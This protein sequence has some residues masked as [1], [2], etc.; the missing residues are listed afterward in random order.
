MSK[1]DIDL[2][3]TCSFGSEEGEGEIKEK[4]KLLL[5]SPLL[6]H[7]DGLPC[8]EARGVSVEGVA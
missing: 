7:F 6:D 4:R 3:R 2:F 8:D 1:T 5:G